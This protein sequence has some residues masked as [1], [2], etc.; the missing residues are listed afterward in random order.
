MNLIP[1]SQVQSDFQNQLADFS[2]YEQQGLPLGGLISPSTDTTTQKTPVQQ[3]SFAGTVAGSV[4]NHLLTGGLGGLFTGVSTSRVVAFILGFILV[5]M[6][7][8]IFG[9]QSAE[10]GVEIVTGSANRAQRLKEGLT[11]LAAA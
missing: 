1:F 6:A 4:A 8:L 5:G 2:N 11:T 7:L 10:K 9:F 3:A